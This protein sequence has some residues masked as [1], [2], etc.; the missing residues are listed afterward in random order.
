[1]VQKQS[2]FPA[3]VLA[4]PRSWYA[5]EGCFHV[6]VTWITSYY[7]EFFHRFVSFQETGLTALLPH[8][9]K[10]SAKVKRQ[11][12][13]IINYF[14]FTSKTFKSRET[15]QNRPRRDTPKTAQL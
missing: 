10:L 11:S 8:Y 1:M 9:Y 5:S 14:G 6:A 15:P 4:Q 3:I 12:T 7:V 13:K 2:G